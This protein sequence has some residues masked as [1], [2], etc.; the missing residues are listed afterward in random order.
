MKTQRGED[1]SFG[2]GQERREH[3]GM[4]VSEKQREC[5]LCGKAVRK[6]GLKSNVYHGICI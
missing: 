3:D 1:S 6:K 5:C 2:K 4:C